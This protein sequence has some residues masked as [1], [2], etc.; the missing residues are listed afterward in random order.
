MLR[1]KAVLLMR[2]AEA[3]DTKLKAIIRN[4]GFIMS[5]KHDMRFFTS[6]ELSTFQ[7]T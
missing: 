1:Y 5:V 2:C 4:A 3:A 7:L 6:Y